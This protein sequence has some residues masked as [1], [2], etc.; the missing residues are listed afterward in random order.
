MTLNKYRFLIALFSLLI[1]IPTFAQNSQDGTYSNDENDNDSVVADTSTVTPSSL[2][3]PANIK[4][5]IDG[6]LQNDLF[7]TSQVGIEV[8]DLTDDSV[9]YSYNQKQRM[10]PASTMKL[11]TAIT[12]INNLGGSYQFRTQLYYTGSIANNTLTGNVYCLGGFDPRFNSDD[13]NAFVESIHRMGVDTIRGTLYG[14]TSMKDEDRLG[15]GWCWD[16]GEDPLSPL[17]IS[18]KDVFMTRFASELRDAGVVVEG[19][20]STGRVPN[21]A[22]SICTRFHSIDQILM[23]MMKESDNLYAE[24]MFYQIAASQGARPAT[25]KNARNVINQLISK[26]GYRP[27][28]YDIADGSG[29]SLYNYVSPE[30]EVAFLRYAYR[31]SNVY[32]HLFP[33]LPIAGRDGTLKNRMRSGMVAGNVHA[34]TGTVSAVASLAGYCTSANGHTLCFSI[35]NQG[36]TRARLGRN[37]QDRVCQALCEP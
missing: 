17:L 25:Y 4:Q 21:G 28:D 11:I 30:L 15:N 26:I 20:V 9:I 36:V 2:P 3:W 33:S 29:L 31:N 37:F 8:Y 12:A 13:M 16:D 23:R 24:S 18:R 22:Y 34:K 10:R 1:Q 6:Y 7:R 19:Q 14:D 5:R 32:L 35:I 27:S